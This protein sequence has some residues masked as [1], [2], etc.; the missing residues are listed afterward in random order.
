[1]SSAL[2]DHLRESR[3]FAVWF[4]DLRIWSVAGFRRIHWEWPEE[5]IRP[6]A[7]A[8]IRRTDEVD[9]QERKLQELQ[10]ITIHFD[11]TLEARSGKPNSDFKG[12]LFF[13]APGDVVYSKIDV[14]NGAIAIVPEHMPNAIVSSEFPVYRVRPEVALPAY[15]KLLFKTRHFRHAING[16]I[17]GTSGRKRVQPEQLADLKVP[18]PPLAIQRAIIQRFEKGQ[19]RITKSLNR[20][21]QVQDSIRKS[22][23]SDLGLTL[24]KMN[25][26]PR[27]FAARWGDMTRWSVRATHSLRQAN[28]SGGKYPLVLGKDCLMEVRHGCSCSPSPVPTS[29]KVLK[30]SSVTRG[31]FL[32]TESKYAP[33]KARFRREFDLKAGDV[34][35][36]RTN[37]TLEYVGMSALVTEDMQDLIFPDKIIRVRV[38]N[39]LL[40]E[41]LWVLLQSAPMRAQI[42]AA[43]RTAVGNYAIGSDDIWNLKIPLPPTTKQKEIMQRVT[44]GHQQILR[45]QQSISKLST[46][47]GREVE[48]LIMGIRPVSELGSEV[49]ESS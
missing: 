38:Q 6:L 12:R 39:N 9:R 15:I 5:Y 21:Q 44:R 42:E 41:Y 1:M 25:K 49:Y 22:F 40:P 30:I 8:L 24:I 2:S 48:E 19:K 31:E 43:A 23:G 20:V 33:D 28:V 27:A 32:P 18:L 46:Q 26:S 35:M 10:L 34:L 4:R 3:A 29:L 13:A 37:G 11:G 7:S 36:C 45:E 47:V 17:S 16:L 14:R